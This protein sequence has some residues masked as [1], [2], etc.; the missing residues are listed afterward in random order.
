MRISGTIVRLISVSILIAI[1]ATP[2]AAAQSADT[3]YRLIELRPGGGGG[4]TKAYALNNTGQIVGWMESDANRHSA[5]WH[6]EVTTDL[7]GTV[8]FEL[9]HPYVYFNVPYSE[10]Y[11][12]SNADQ[13]VGTAHTEIECPPP[14]GTVL[15]TNA[16]ILRAAVLTDS[17]TPYP[18]DALTNLGTLGY[19]CGAWDS[20]ATGVSN[21]NHVVG[22]ADIDNT[23]M[24]ATLITPIDGLWYRDDD[25]DGINDLL[26]DLGTLPPA[27]ADPV[28]CATA[29]ND[30][31]QVTGYSYTTT[32]DGD[33]AYHAFKIWPQDTDLDGTADRWYV[34][35]NGVN[36]L[37]ADLGT[38]GGTNS[39]GR[40][41]NSQGQ[42]VGESDYEPGSGQHYTRAF[43]FDSGVMTNLGTLGGDFSA[44][45]AINDSGVIVGWAENAAGQRR[46]FIRQGGE[47]KDLNEMLC[48]QTDAGVTIVPSI[49]LTE[50]RD[51]NED[52]VICGWGAVRGSDN[53]ATRGFLLLPID[54]ND[55]VV[56]EEEE[57]EETSES[58]GETGSGTSTAG[59]EFEGTPIGGTPASM[60]ATGSSGDTSSS[61]SEEQPS[62]IP[63]LCG[64]G[65]FAFL[66]LM[67]V[68]LCWMKASATRWTRRT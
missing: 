64:T 15:I 13:I 16:F 20:A 54:P 8:H 26:I 42:V 60:G 56:E 36:N 46:A 63:L 67:V 35:V 32:A 53:Q 10:S 62:A 44:A 1:A 47:L 17:A 65:T 48:L 50:A 18:G 38:L 58:G 12:I 31:G 25:L 14:L 55:C 22:W 61:E 28:S 9:K 23:R 45:S 27:S 39:W 7:H 43:L 37:M 30:A 24:H 19:A 41:I 33:A 49:V 4:S 59:A 21:Q 29:V 5:H 34:G 66:P 68:G 51:I 2:P 52:G 57:E 11:D 3:M 40:D 6:I